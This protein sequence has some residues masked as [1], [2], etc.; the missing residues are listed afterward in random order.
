MSGTPIALK[1]IKQKTK[2]SNIHNHHQK[3]ENMGTLIKM[4]AAILALIAG[5]FG[6]AIT[7]MLLMWALI[8]VV[9]FFSLLL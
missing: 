2:D 3:E 8:D 7:M 9:P 1:L 4:V 6:M 5:P